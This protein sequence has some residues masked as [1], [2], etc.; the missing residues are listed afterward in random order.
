MIN[1]ENTGMTVHGQGMQIMN[2]LESL[3]CVG[4][5][6]LFLK[7]LCLGVLKGF[8]NRQAWQFV[9]VTGKKRKEIMEIELFHAQSHYKRFNSCEPA[10][11]SPLLLKHIENCKSKSLCAAPSLP[12][13]PP[14]LVTLQ[15]MEAVRMGPRLEAQPNLHLTW[16][17]GWY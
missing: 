5:Y 17:C 7:A 8:L 11:D 10:P 6:C 1:S 9:L 12:P 14:W 2:R 4:G 3:L 16:E 15:M 13:I